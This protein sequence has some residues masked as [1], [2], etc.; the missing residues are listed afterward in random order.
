M[1]LPLRAAARPFSPAAATA[2]VPAGT[3]LLALGEPTHGVEEFLDLRN[4]LFRHLVAEHGY[5]SLA[6]ESDCLA[7]LAV[8]AYV[9]GGDGE[10]GA[11][12]REGLSH[13]FGEYRGNR[14]LIRWMREFNEQSAEGEWLRLYGADGPLEITGAAAPGPAL[15]RLHDCLAARLPAELLPAREELVLL[16]GPDA[17][18]TEPA[19]V[20]DPSRSVGRTPE[21]GRLRLLA[22]ELAGTLAA[23]RPQFAAEDGGEAL[24]RAESDARTALGLLR[25]HAAVA[26][27]GPDRIGSLMRQRDLM[28]AENLRAIVRREDRRGPTLVFAHNRHLQREASRIPLGDHQLRWW[29]AGALFASHEDGYAHLACT[30]GNRGT[31]DRP[32]P[33]SLE[34]IL[35]TLPDAR[36]V[37][38]PR[39]LAAAVAGRAVARVP[40]D[41]TYFGLDPDALG[42]VEG[43]LFVRDIPRQQGLFGG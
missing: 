4:A 13:G 10:L 29:S 9:Q 40:A 3:R 24:W 38:D 22:D 36:S 17:R 33:D 21:A 14:E 6:L 35:T 20:R 1:D 11:V 25:Y 43:V 7:A 41:H 28:M 23:H 37:L 18:W 19:A 8:D 39:L 15:L 30:F 31:D 5:R 16:H 2:L 42:G 26:D 27:A 34:G 32:D 12:V